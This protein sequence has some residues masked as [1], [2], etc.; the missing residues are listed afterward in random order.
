MHTTLR[1][2]IMKRFEEIMHKQWL[3]ALLNSLCKLLSISPNTDSAYILGTCSS[4]TNLHYKA[5][6]DPSNTSIS[7]LELVNQLYTDSF[8]SI[9]LTLCFLGF[10]HDALLFIGSSS[11]AACALLSHVTVTEGCVRGVVRMSG[12]ALVRWR[13][14]IR[15]EEVV[16][17]W[18]NEV[19]DNLYFHLNTCSSKVVIYHC[20]INTALI[21]LLII[22]ATMDVQPR[23]PVSPHYRRIA[24]AAAGSDRKHPGKAILAGLFSAE[25]ILYKVYMWCYDCVFWMK[26]HNYM[27]NNYA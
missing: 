10:A 4:F 24:A 26:G 8:F 11:R 25:F 22:A 16:H 23:S 6:F 7:W 27:S 3:T 12:A 17:E 13:S 1:C 21:S 9:K 19:V 20:P 2:I 5:C 15:T 14:R 18:G